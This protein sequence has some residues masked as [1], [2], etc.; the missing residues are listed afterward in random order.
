ML[1][2]T[3][4]SS[5]DAT[6]ALKYLIDQSENRILL[7]DQSKKASKHCN[8]K[9]PVVTVYQIIYMLVE[10]IRV[11]TVNLHGTQYVSRWISA[12]HN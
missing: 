4:Y 10:K 11:I 12:C 6:N 9:W 3:R 5:F 8:I 2:F 7:I 1:G